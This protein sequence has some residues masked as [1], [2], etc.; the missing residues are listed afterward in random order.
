MTD[1]R[2]LVL[3]NLGGRG[4]SRRVEGGV[5]LLTDAGY[6]VEVLFARNPD[7]IP[8]AI[9]ERGSKVDVI[10]IGG[11]D[12]TLSH[13]CEAVLASGRPLGILPLGN[14][15]DLARTLGLPTAPLAA[16]RVIA[17]G[18]TTRIDVGRVNGR[19]F[20]N[21]ASMGI[22]V[23][24]ARRLT[25]QLKSRWGVLGY[26]KAAWD[27]TRTESSFAARITCDGETETLRA[28]QVAVG[29]GRYYGG[30]MTV[31]DDAAIDDNR[32]DVYAIRRVANWRWLTLLPALFRGKHRHHAE[33]TARHGQNV[34]IETK[35]P[36]KINVDGEVIAETPADFT[37]EPAALEVFVP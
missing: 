9:S 14:A 7:R 16:F 1:K 29:N 22:S 37:V 25:G 27:A 35:H 32:L 10:V 8:D 28:I 30:G 31:A 34:R 17:A 6:E 26:A 4:A 33:V 19:P 20:F 24:I 2:A 21:V 3:V 5:K 18:K 15:N 13:A 11:G 23:A 36:R 12:G